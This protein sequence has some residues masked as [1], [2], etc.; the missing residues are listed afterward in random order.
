M[1]NRF[2]TVQYSTNP[3]GKEQEKTNIMIGI[4]QIMNFWFGSLMDIFICTYMVPA[5]KKGRMVRPRGNRYGILNP[6][7]TTSGR[8]RSFIQ[9]VKGASFSSTARPN[10]LNRAMKIGICKSTGKQPI[11]PQSGFTPSFL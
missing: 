6:S 11:T 10:T 2:D 5:M 3:E 7:S 9:R 8:E 1:V 4:I